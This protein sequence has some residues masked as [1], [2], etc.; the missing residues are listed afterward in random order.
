MSKKQFFIFFIFAF[1]SGICNISPAQIKTHGLP[2]IKNYTIDDYKGN[3]F[4]ATQNWY[5]YQDSKGMMYFANSGGLLFFDGIHWTFQVVDETSTFRSINGTSDDK[6]FAGGKGEFGYLTN[7]SIGNIIYQSLVN[8][9]PDNE[10][11]FTDIWNIYTFP[12]KVIF[13]TTRKLFIYVNDTINIVTT[14]GPTLNTFKKDND[15]FVI[16]QTKGLHKLVGNNLEW[17]LNHQIFDSYLFE[18]EGF[19][20]SS[21]I[22][23]RNHGFYELH[24][25][26]LKKWHVD[27]E[28]III[29]KKPYCG[30]KLDSE[31]IAIGTQ[32]GGIFVINSSG[33][34]K[35]V[36]N[37]QNGLQANTVYNLYLDNTKNLWAALGNGISYL[38][39]NSPFTYF[40][41]L[42]NIPRKNYDVQKINNKLYVSNEVGIHYKPIASVDGNL[43][44][45]NFYPIEGLSGIT[46]NLQNYNNLLIAANSYGLYLI[47]NNKVI[48]KA[49]DGIHFWNVEKIPGSTNK[50]FGMSTKGLHTFEIRNKSIKNAVKVSNYNNTM[51]YT[52]VENDTKLWTTDEVNGIN[53]IILSKDHKKVDTT[54]NLKFG[55]E[56]I[57][58]YPFIIKNQVFVASSSKIYKIESDSFKIANELIEKYNVKNDVF[59]FTYDNWDRLWI[60][61]DTKIKWRN[62][63][64]EEI[65]Q[66]FLPLY[67]ENISRMSILSERD[68]YFPTD[69][70]VIHYDPTYPFYEDSNFDIV[71]HSIKNINN[72]S[73]I[74]GMYN[75][76][77]Q[78][79]LSLNILDS[80]IILPYDINNLRFSYAATY[81]ER[82][83]ETKYQ[84]WLE[85]F[86][87]NNMNWSK[88]TRKDYTNLRPGKYIFHVKAKN[89]YGN[90]SAEKTL[91]FE[92]KPPFYLSS[93]A[94][95]LYIIIAIT[96]FYLILQFYTRQ[97]KARNR[98]LEELVRERTMEIETQ[99]EEILSQSEQLMEYNEEL[100][101]LSVVASE[102]NNAVFITDHMG[103]IEWVNEGFQRVYGQSFYDV[104]QKN[105]AS[106]FTNSNPKYIEKMFKDVRESRKAKTFEQE[107]ITKE[108]KRTY[109]NTTLTPLLNEDKVVEKIVAIDSDI[110]ELKQAENEILQ[111]KEEILNQNEELEKHRLHL[112]DLVNERTRELQ[113]ALTKAE[114][115]DRLKSSFLMNMSHEIRTPM[116]AI[117]GFCEILES[118]ENPTNCRSYIQQITNNSNTLLQLI[119]NI[120]N[121]SRLESES[122]ELAISSFDLNKMVDQIYNEHIDQ[123]KQKRLKLSMSKS[124]LEP[125]YVSSD[126]QLLYLIFH[127]L[128]Q[129]AFKYT[130]KGEVIFGY[131][132][133]QIEEQLQL[134][135][136]V[137]DTGIGM[138]EEDLH[139]VFKRFTKIE[140][141]NRKLYR[142]AG[143]GLAL[144]QKAVE[145][146]NGKIWIKSE[147][148]KGTTVNFTLQ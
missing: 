130:A 6:I 77:F 140:D 80:T 109:V 83:E 33:E 54:I 67:G 1:L 125:M 135:C 114:E 40:N 11:S 19:N 81:Y 51:R 13:E 71:F 123:F 8:K 127:Q 5:I 61:S 147:P 141:N 101:K 106:L 146:I 10:R 55:K 36:Y 48:S 119:D 22:I 21:L 29:K 52:I 90:Q 85:G 92:I 136:Y 12:D 64:N 56:K 86:E 50:Y 143:I 2:H 145:Q 89:I 138:N 47:E 15:L 66:P 82:P 84:I 42:L 99:N 28:N 46:Y 74:A 16:D 148:E 95:L 23:S 3:E 39:L 41:P 17:V 97:L 4:G 100:R 91:T 112:E 38:K 32:L 116:N 122:Y 30:V 7:D 44:T 98:K 105:R 103:N 96:I 26:A 62:K 132:M 27:N 128:I 70:F 124:Q 53:K 58:V 43:N 102:V 88:E 14:A 126:Q 137:Q 76:L 113:Q 69:K 24:E 118:E 111:Q 94:Y 9:L 72:D 87:N 115:S 104:K 144:C 45:I 75:H 93:W 139:Q 110:T 117:V 35:Q 57:L 63:N 37:K 25:D 107:V 65:K 34:I 134:I 121:L 68:V 78:D 18:V 133:K 20:N 49:F 129:N 79:S 120:I 31:H 131:E 142:G 59:W 73:I 60:Q 108:G